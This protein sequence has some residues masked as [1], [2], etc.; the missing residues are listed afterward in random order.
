VS[1][2]NVNACGFIATRIATGEKVIVAVI[3]SGICISHPEIAVGNDTPA[4]FGVQSNRRPH[5]WPPLAR[6]TSMEFIGTAVL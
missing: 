3:D 5:P 6:M 2:S 4:A 1:A